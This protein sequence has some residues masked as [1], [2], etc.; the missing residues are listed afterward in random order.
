VEPLRGEAAFR[1]HKT[2]IAKR[3]ELARAEGAAQRAEREAGIAARW[4]AAER[5]ERSHYPR[6]PRP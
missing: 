2:E 6:Q 5:L 1:A 3:N 4:L